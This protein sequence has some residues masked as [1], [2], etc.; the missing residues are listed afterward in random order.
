MQAAGTAAAPVTL[1][2]EQ[3]D[4]SMD[5]HKP[6]PVHNL[7]E[8]LSEISIIVI[9]VL[10]ALTAE[11]V[12]ESIHWRHAAQEADAAMRKELTED[13]GPQ[14][15]ERIAQSHCIDAQLDTLQAALLT[16]RDTGAPF[17]AVA[18]HI[19]TYYTWDAD[20]YHQ[21]MASST[22]SH[23]ST[24]RAYAWSSPYTLMADLDAA[25]LRE[26]NDYSEL[27]MIEVAPP[28]P[29]DPMRVQLLALIARARGDNALL[30]E[31]IGH[32]IE[33]SAQPDVTYTRAEKEMQLKNHRGI[34]P[35][36]AQ[37][38]G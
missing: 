2:R 13:D 16:E 28:H 25:S 9:G 20:A 23:M 21:A 12:V 26:A 19:P 30:T 31:K 32:F 4:E 22:L 29:S 36:C 6:K 17:R 34:F 8:F 11:Q 37:T 35:G 15:F 5:I 1:P 10:I 18:L 38:V 24:A 33:Y 7:R 3:A 14:A 27:R